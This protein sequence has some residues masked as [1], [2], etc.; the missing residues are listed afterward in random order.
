LVLGLCILGRIF[1]MGFISVPIPTLLFKEIV[2]VVVTTA[3]LLPDN[4][5]VLLYGLFPKGISATV[6]FWS[7]GF[8]AT[9]FAIVFL[10]VYFRVL[11]NILFNEV[12]GS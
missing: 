2:V 11:E 8:S 9:V 4:V 1:E 6:I 7:I 3:L 10:V 12:E 5:V